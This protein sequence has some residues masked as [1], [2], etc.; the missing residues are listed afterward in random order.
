MARQGISERWQVIWHGTDEVASVP[1]GAFHRLAKSLVAY[2]ISIGLGLALLRP[3]ALWLI[4]SRNCDFEF[5][6][7]LY[8]DVKKICE[9]R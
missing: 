5:L 8:S 9:S 4:A 1:S 6:H 2:G 3:R 7:T